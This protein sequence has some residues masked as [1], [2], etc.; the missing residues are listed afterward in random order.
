M[1]QSRTPQQSA[2]NKEEATSALN[3]RH[4][5]FACRSATRGWKL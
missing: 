2:G 3:R 5:F 1:T 4:R